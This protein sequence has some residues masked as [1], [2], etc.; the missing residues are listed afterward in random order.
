MPKSCLVS[1]QNSR[2]HYRNNGHQIV[3]APNL[4]VTILLN[5]APNLPVTIS[6][7]H[8]TSQAPFCLVT[9]SP[10]WA[11]FRL[12][13]EPPGHHFVIWSPFCLGTISYG[14][15]FENGYHFVWAPNLLGTISS[16]GHHFVWAPYL[17]RAPIRL[18]T[19]SPRILR[20]SYTFLH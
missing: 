16:Y 9:K 19:K 11:P 17:H 1:I 7:R 20:Q 6:F 12:G 13:T 8:L 4:L 14:H 2:W 5:W 15:H 18:G 10:P 3:W